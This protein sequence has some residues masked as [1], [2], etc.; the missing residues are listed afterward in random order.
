[1]W[2]KQSSRFVICMYVCVC[3]RV[4]SGQTSRRVGV[5]TRSTAG[6]IW[7][8]HH[9]YAILVYNLRARAKLP[10]PFA[11]VLLASWERPRKSLLLWISIFLSFF[12]SF[13]KDIARVMNVKKEHTH[14]CDGTVFFFFHF[15][16]CRLNM[17]RTIYIRC[18]EYNSTVLGW[19][20]Y[21]SCHVKRVLLIFTYI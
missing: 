17:Q 3:T 7:A 9:Q 21:S 14:T 16:F 6:C 4:S 19:D 1:M 10:T 13:V 8:R 15:G 2:I 18:R 11:P 5:L 20:T 12:F